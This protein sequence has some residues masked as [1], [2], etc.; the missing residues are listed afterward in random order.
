VPN[1]EVEPFS[2]GV[3]CENCGAPASGS[4]ITVALTDATGKFTLTD[5]PAGTNIPLVIQI[6]RWRRQVVIPQVTECVNN[7]LPAELTRLP[8]NKAEGDIPHI[9]IA[10]SIYDAEECILRKIGIDDAEFTPLNLDGRVHIYQGSGATLPGS[11]G[12]ETLWG[13]YALLTNYDIVLRRR[14]PSTSALP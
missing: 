10:S 6:G 7:E 5:V 1:A 3:A 4:P 11:P 9:A 12:M 14:D 2:F 8:R 13:D